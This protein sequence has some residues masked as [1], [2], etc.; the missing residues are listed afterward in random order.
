MIVLLGY[1]ATGHLGGRTELGRLRGRL[2]GSGGGC[3]IIVRPNDVFFPV[4]FFWIL[5]SVV[6]RTSRNRTMLHARELAEKAERARGAAATRTNAGPSRPSA[7]A[8]AR[9]AARR[10]GAQPQRDGRAGQRRAPGPW[11]PRAQSRRPRLIERPGREALA[12]LRH[13]FGPVR[14]GDGEPLS[15]PQSIAR[16]HELA[17]RARDAGLRV[18][19]RVTG[20]PV[21]LPAGIDL[22]AYRIIQEALTNTLRALRRRQRA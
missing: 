11:T 12:Q 14:R 6:G 2:R 1:A 13:L 22:A 9:R 10:P 18:E 20:D 8:S 21:Q 5:P 15:G 16:V 19:L 7:T 4:T 3:A 17:R